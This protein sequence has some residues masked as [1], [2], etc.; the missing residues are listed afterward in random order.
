[1]TSAPNPNLPKP[2]FC[3][4]LNW[5]TSP[6]FTLHWL[7]TSP[8]HFKHVGHLKITMNLDDKGMPMA[9][10][11]GK[12]GQEISA[13]AGEGVVVAQNIALNLLC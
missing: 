6:A 5:S 2:P 1:M 9:V 7:A 12:D 13:E 11:I 3:A 8:I 10:L 4:K